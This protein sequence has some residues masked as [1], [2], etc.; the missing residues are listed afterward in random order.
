MAGIGD[1]DDTDLD[2]IK[3]FFDEYADAAVRNCGSRC[4]WLIAS[5]ASSR[6]LQTKTPFPA[7]VHQPLQQQ[8]HLR[9]LKEA[10]GFI[11]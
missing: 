8:V 2:T 7:A 1:G 4:N 5:S 9:G 10:T 11:Q 6:L 3:P